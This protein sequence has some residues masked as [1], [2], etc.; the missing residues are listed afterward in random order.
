MRVAL[1]VVW[2]LTLCLMVN[3]QEPVQRFDTN[4]DGQIDQGEYYEA[5]ALTRLEKYR[6]YDQR[7]F[8]DAKGALTRVTSNEDGNVGFRVGNVEP[9]REEEWPTSR[10]TIS[11]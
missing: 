3:A 5:D 4:A 2:L 1:A 7:E 8:Y 11:R 6:D 9:I 10:S